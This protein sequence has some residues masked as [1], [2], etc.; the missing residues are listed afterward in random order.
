MLSLG[1]TC[2]PSM[3]AVECETG[4]AVWATVYGFSHILNVLV[5]DQAYRW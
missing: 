4:H 2:S 5:L 3:W 1:L